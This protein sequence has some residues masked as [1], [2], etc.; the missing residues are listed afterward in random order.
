MAV[1]NSAAAPALVIA[2][3]TATGKTALAVE[4]ALALRGE[5]ICADSMQVYRGLDIG[6]AGPGPKELA[7]VPHHLY[8]MLDP[9]E[10]YSVA[11][12]VHDALAAARGISARGKLPVLCG[13]TGQYISAFIGETVFPPEQTDLR[14]RR[15]LYA[16]IEQNGPQKLLDELAAADSAFARALHPNDT[17]RIVRAVELLRTTGYTIP[18]QN[19]RSRKENPEFSPFVAVLYARDRSVL[20]ARIE[21]RAD[22][23]LARGLLDEARV[24]HENRERFATAAQAIGYKEFFPYFDG[25]ADFQACTAAFKQ[26]TRNYAKRQLTWFRR[27]PSAVWYDIEDGQDNIAENIINEA[28]RRSSP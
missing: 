9:A 7:A 15:A 22:R 4:A 23:M 2:G 10:R 21:V 8:G 25:T 14:L 13:G 18:Q 26:A 24:V 1:S 17:K 11:R 12:Y 16:D 20:Y 6:T 5:I 27:I 19:E 3:P 28:N